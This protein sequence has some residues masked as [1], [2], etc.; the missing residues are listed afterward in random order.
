MAEHA[1][2]PTRINLQIAG[3]PS[4]YRDVSGSRSRSV[5]TFT[6]RTVARETESNPG[7]GTRFYSF[8]LHA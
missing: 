7:N 5:L 4:A 1:S 3:A 8:A 6:G 2:C